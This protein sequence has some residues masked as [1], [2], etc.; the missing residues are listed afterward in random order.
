MCYPEYVMKRARLLTIAPFASAVVAGC[1]LGVGS[2]RAGQDTTKP[3]QKQETQPS[4]PAT[5]PG[6]ALDFLG[7]YSAPQAVL[8]TET[9]HTSAR[10]PSATTDQRLTELAADLGKVPVAPAELRSWLAGMLTTADHSAEDWFR[11]GTGALEAARAD[12]RRLGEVAPSSAWNQRLEA[13]ALAGRYP[14]LSKSVWDGKGQAPA[15]PSAEPSKAAGRPAIPL[16]EARSELE[17]IDN[18]P[19]SPEN[20][21][22]RARLLV[23]VSEE[24]FVHAATS[25]QLDARLY[26]LQALAAEDENDEGGAL[27]EYQSGLA[28]YPDSALLHAGLGHLDRERNDLEPARTELERS[29]RLDPTDALVGFELGDVELRMGKPAE[30]IEMLNHALGLDPNLLVA[31]WAR[32]RAY[33]AA[34]G[35]GSDQ[36]ALEDL[37]AAESCDRTGVLELQIAQVDS[38]LGRAAEAG[39]HRRRSEEQRQALAATKGPATPKRD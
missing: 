38:R 39:D 2:A 3:A 8:A 34:G 1:L 4:K 13:E 25:P 10:P 7:S 17:R 27:K 36:R 24:A 15:Q 23:G 18:L 32:G 19:E 5:D 29:W 30:A 33:L 20:L 12:S 28:R 31:R 35:E 9:G 21:Y 14:A 22:A 6:A 26:A 37:T 11:I 16:A